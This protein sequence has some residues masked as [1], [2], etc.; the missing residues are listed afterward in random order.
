M[1]RNASYTEAI[2]RR[3]HALVAEFGRQ[4]GWVAYDG[5][6]EALAQRYWM[7]ALRNAHVSGDR[8]I[9]ANI[10]GFLSIPAAHSARPGDAVDLARSALQAGSKL[11]PAVASATYVRLSKAAAAAGDSYTSRR[12]SDRAAELLRRSVPEEEP[13]WIYWFDQAELDGSSGQA[14]LRLR[15]FA[16]AEAQLRA[17]VAGFEPDC[18][19]ERALF[20]CDLAKARFGAGSLD[21]AC[22]TAGEAA[23]VIRRLNSTRDRHRLREFRQA[24]DRY[25][26]TAAVR[27]FDDKHGDLYADLTA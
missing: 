13:P 19:R 26:G 6:D 8:A 5:G 24:V 17:A 7:A 20:M 1:L 2:G 15:R 18:V 22:A 27:Q 11:T 10:L 23:V 9:G 25:A 12:A 3:L 21:Q 4:A 14:A 16:E